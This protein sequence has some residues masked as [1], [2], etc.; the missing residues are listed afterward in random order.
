VSPPTDA[1]EIQKLLASDAG[2]DDQFGRSLF[3]SADGNTAIIG[4]MLESTSPNTYNGAAYIFIKSV[5]IWVQQAKLLASDAAS[6]DYFG[7][8]VSLS[9]DGNTAIIGA[10][11]EDTGANTNNGAAYIFTRSGS[12][13]T[14]Q[15]K[16]LASDAA[17][18]DSFGISVSLSADGNTAMVGA[19]AESTSPNTGNGAVYVFTRSGTTWTQQQKLLAS[20]AASTED[21]GWSIAL[22][23]DGSTALIGARRENTSPNTLNGAAYVFTRSGSTWTQQAKLVA[24]DPDALDFFGYSVALSSSGNTAIVGAYLEDTPPNTSNGAAYVFTRSGTTWT[25]QQKLLASDPAPSDT[26]GYSVSIS[27]DGNT[28]LI[29]AY[30]DDKNTLSINSGAAYIFTRSGT[31]WTEQFKL[32]AS[33]SEANDQFGY[34]SYLSADGST[35]FVGANTED[36]GTNTNNGAVYVYALG[37]RLDNKILSY[38]STSN[39]WETI[40]HQEIAKP[41][42]Y[43]FSSSGSWEIPV[44]ARMVNVVCVGAGGGGGGGGR[45]IPGGTSSGGG[46]G[47]GGGGVSEFM[48]RASD[49]GGAG[50]YI[51]IT[52]GSG[53]AGGAATASGTDFA[54]G[55]AGS[56]GG[57]TSFGSY[58]KSIG[59]IAGPGGTL[60][61]TSVEESG[62]G[63]W[64]GNYS[65]LS[66]SAGG[67]GGG[68][69]GS[70]DSASVSGSAGSI[71]TSV[72]LTATT[73][74]GA[75]GAS[76]TF[77][78][79]AG[80]GGHGGQTSTGG[81]GFSGGAGG[82]PGG[83]GGGG[84]EGS[85]TGSTGTGGAGGAGA[86]GMV[87]ITVWYG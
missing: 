44:G 42:T 66:V 22:S 45:N 82:F 16:L 2:V 52:I 73:T 87:S 51:P 21:F 64:T 40:S 76:N 50:T 74:S 27:A 25:Q 12:T 77:Y 62:F 83:G 80:A 75:A 37:K 13:W 19:Y 71:P 29:S 47:G 54:S 5:G 55:N 26:F 49:L 63:M 15:A 72:N 32:S 6:S 23:L 58:L 14:Q 81:T 53:G 1:V 79:G 31:T 34:L 43:V 28:A 85:I 57:D 7:Q 59:G 10:F 84:G 78:N 11:Q 3:I 4:A 38:S 39:K 61:G 60:G 9:A 41:S 35:V 20:D 86:A 48:F 36:T 17:T 70:S 65:S 18:E 68:R 8:S 24:S 67:G 69:G 46:L 33:D 56:A 30:A